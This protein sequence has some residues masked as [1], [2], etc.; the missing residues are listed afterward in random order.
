MAATDL[1]LFR[2]EQA[3]PLVLLRACLRLFG[4][5]VLEWEPTVVKRSI[6][7]ATEATVSRV[8]F[9]KILA[10]LTVANRDNFWL[11]WETF[12]FLSQALNNN[13]PS[14]GAIQDQSVGQMMVAVDIAASIRKELGTLSEVP[15]FSDEVRRYIAAQLSEAGIW[16]VPEP[17]TFVNPL[18]S[19]LTQVCGECDNEEEPQVDGLCSYCTDRYDADSLLKLEPDEE[20]SK[21]YDGSKVRVI[22]KFKTLPVQKRLM[23]YLTKPATVLRE[24][25]ADICTAKIVTGLEYMMHRRAQLSRQE[26]V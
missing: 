5:E 26:A 15:E 24:T 23:D 21:K 11:E 1:Q 2:D 25:Q 8:N 16:F 9:V 6:E 19:G 18:I 14:A 13:L 17:L 10:A 3:H 20:L 22:E 4:A 12:H 7:D